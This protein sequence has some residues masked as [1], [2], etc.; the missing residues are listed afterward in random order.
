MK[1]VTVEEAEEIIQSKT[2]QLD[3]EQVQLTH[4]LGRVLD[5]DIITDRDL[6]PF[7]RATMDGIAVNYSNAD[8]PPHKY[9]IT[10]TQAAGQQPITISRRNEC[11]EIMTGAALSPSVNTVI[12]YENISISK[13]IAKVKLTSIKKGQNIHKKGSDKRIGDIIAAAHQ[14]I[15]PSVIGVCASVGKTSVQVKKLPRVIVIST[16]DELIDMNMTPSS[17]QLRKSNSITISSILKLYGI[18]SD[19]QHL[20]DDTEQIRKN[21]EHI[22]KNY[23]VILLSGGVSM[24][25]FD[26][27]PKI[28]EDLGVDQHFHTVRQRPGKPFWFGSYRKSITVFAFPGNPIS[29]FM[30]MHRY[31]LPWL[32]MSLRLAP[33]PHRYAA[34]NKNITFPLPLQ[35]FMQVKLKANRHG[36]LIAQPSE[37]NGSGDF[38]NLVITDAFLELPQNRNIFKKGETFK[39]WPYTKIY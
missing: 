8:K 35:Y 19:I 23:D 39:V 1:M 13:N 11:V 20:Q 17:Y 31:F 15:T 21:L 16:G 5:E 26:Y 22:I 28:L 9:T 7:N 27:I 37:G 38:A 10:G 3:S 29:T 34:L 32:K 14:L 36:Q 33:Q 24:G 12:P 2:I 30:C 25:K 4:S 18:Q 6:P